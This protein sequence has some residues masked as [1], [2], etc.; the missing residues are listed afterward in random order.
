MTPEIGKI[1][2]QVKRLRVS[3]HVNANGVLI[4]SRLPNTNTPIPDDFKAGLAKHRDTLTSMLSGNETK[5][6][7]EKVI[8]DGPCGHQCRDCAHWENLYLGF[9]VSGNVCRR[10]DLRVAA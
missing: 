1:L 5:A 6:T 3:L 10:H 7:V 9:P 4:L 2:G 8:A